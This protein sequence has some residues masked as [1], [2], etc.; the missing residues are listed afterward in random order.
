MWHGSVALVN[1]RG[2]TV[3]M[4]KISESSRRAMICQAKKLL[5]SVGQMPSAVEQGL[6]AIHYRKS[7]SDEEVGRLP[8]TWCEIPPIDDGGGLIVLERDT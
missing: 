5:E 2:A 7:L 8:L 3:P 4:E 6:L 1:G